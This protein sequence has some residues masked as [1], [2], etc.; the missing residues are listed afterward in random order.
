MELQLKHLAPYLPYRLKV[1]KDDWGRVFKMDNDGTTLNC[2]GIDY[3]LNI[4]AKPILRP[5]SDLTKEIEVNGG[6]V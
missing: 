3:I 5:L 6:Y 2:I 1:T 4:N